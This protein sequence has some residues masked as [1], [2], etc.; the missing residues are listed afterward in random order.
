M[1]YIVAWDCSAAHLKEH[2]DRFRSVSYATG[3]YAYLPSIIIDGDLRFE[4]NKLKTSSTGTT[5]PIYREF[6]LTTVAG[7]SHEEPLSDRRGVKRLSPGFVVRTGALSLAL[8]RACG[9]DA[10]R[11]DGIRQPHRERKESSEYPSG[12]NASA[13]QASGHRQR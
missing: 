6:F 12:R 7:G 1:L 3:Y 4:N 11:L 9:A 5:P 2:H 8:Y 10:L 13:P